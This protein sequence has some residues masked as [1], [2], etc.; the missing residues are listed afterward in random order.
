MP[1]ATI[2]LTHADYARIMPL[3][4]GAVAPEGIKLKVMARSRLNAEP[5]D[6]RS[7]G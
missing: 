7:D 6:Q 1:E 3:V 4:T 5:S 2:T